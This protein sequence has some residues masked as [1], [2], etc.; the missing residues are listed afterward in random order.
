[1]T[2]D[3][4]GEAIRAVARAVGSMPLENCMAVIAEFLLFLHHHN[5]TPPEDFDDFLQELR[6]LYRSVLLERRVC[7]LLPNDNLGDG[8]HWLSDA[9]HVVG[10]QRW[11]VLYS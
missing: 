10:R 4:A 11:T 9:Q 6:K 3:E 8:S 2:Q 5:G 7:D 1:M